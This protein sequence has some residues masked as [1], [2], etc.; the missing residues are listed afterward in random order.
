MVGVDVLSI[1]IV[2]ERGCGVEEL[3]RAEGA[4]GAP[5]H[6]GNTGLWWSGSHVGNGAPMRGEKLDGSAR[7]AL[8]Y[9]SL[10]QECRSWPV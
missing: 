3:E 2:G 9:G 10:W 4:R 6:G 8:Y 1:G 7:H 5:L